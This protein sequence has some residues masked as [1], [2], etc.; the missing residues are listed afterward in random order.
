MYLLYLV[1][2]CLQE[3][4]FECFEFVKSKYLITLVL[5]TQKNTKLHFYLSGAVNAMPEQQFII[6]KNW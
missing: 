2:I 3:I 4:L 1:K 6:Y 5:M